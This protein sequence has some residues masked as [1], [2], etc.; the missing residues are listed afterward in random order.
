MSRTAALLV[1]RIPRV[2]RAP[3]E[4]VGWVAVVLRK[5]LVQRR[6]AH[7]I[8]NCEFARP[9]RDVLACPAS[10]SGAEHV[11]ALKGQGLR[12]CVATLWRIQR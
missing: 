5:E 1:F 12:K 7:G 4:L 6:S 3:H 2:C 9:L 10:C 8:F 11:L